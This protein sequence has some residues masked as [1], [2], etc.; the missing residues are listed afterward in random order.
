MGELSLWHWLI[1][2]AA[3]ML[4]FGA[5]RLPQMARSLGQSARILRAETRGLSDDKDKERKNT[6]TAEPQSIESAE[7]SSASVPEAKT[8]SEKPAQA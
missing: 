6:A 8:E 3:L 7:R 4:L 1:I 2:I 5:S